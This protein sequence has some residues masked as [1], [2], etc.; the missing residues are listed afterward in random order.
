MTS[1]DSDGFDRRHAGHSISPPGRGGKRR[2]RTCL[3]AYNASRWAAKHAGHDI[4]THPKSGRRTCATCAVNTADVDAAISGIRMPDLR[5]DE[6][7]L[8]VD[9]LTAKGWS[10]DAISKVLVT[11]P[12]TVHRHRSALRNA[13]AVA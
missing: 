9:A 10:A 3:A 7:R 2:C 11:T 6:R 13:K 8:V 1:Y 12:T 4:R 5:F